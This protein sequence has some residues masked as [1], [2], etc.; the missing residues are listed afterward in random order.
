MKQFPLDAV[1]RWLQSIIVHPG[2]VRAGLAAEATQRHMSLGPLE[3]EQLIPRSSSQTSVERLAVYAN[4][5]YARLIECLESEFP[6]FRQVVG[7]EAFAEFAAAYLQRYPSQSYSLGHLGDNFP[8]YLA[9]TKPAE[10]GSSSLPNWTDFLIEL[11]HL[12]RVF[13][14]V[15]DGP[16]VESHTPLQAT[17]LL[18]VD[19]ERWA[20]SQIQF[21]PCFRLLS[22]QFP[23]NEFY[24]SVRKG[25]NSTIPAPAETWLAVTRRDFVVR[26]YE[27]NRT[28]FVLLSQ[29]QDT[30]TVG[31]S[32]ATAA[33]SFDG[34]FE[35]LSLDLQQWFANWAAAPFFAAVV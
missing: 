13:A 15:F 26:R 4:A 9:E 5:Y 14:D 24:S 19:P 11:A 35:Q 17:D 28:Q 12:E 23:L 32:I 31:E 16:G 34:S 10:D 20:K 27:L 29:L 7:E 6:V 2:G 21:V 25:E 8:R 30:K 1:Q 3:V 33:E 18:S 22:L